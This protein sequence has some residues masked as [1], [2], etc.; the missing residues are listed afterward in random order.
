MMSFLRFLGVNMA[1]DAPE[2]AGQ[3]VRNYLGGL[4]FIVT[5]IGAELMKEGHTY[6]G[7]ALVVAGLPIFL[8]GVLWKWLRT[9]LGNRVSAWLSAI[10]SDSRWWIVSLLVLA[11]IALLLVGP[12]GA[13]LFLVFALSYTVNA[14]LPTQRRDTPATAT[15]PA[16]PRK[17]AQVDRDLLILLD[18]AMYQSAALMIDNLIRSAPA[19]INE[20]FK[21]DASLADT[22]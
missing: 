8:S 15:Q 19:A 11:G 14:L 12:L 20:P 13:T 3:A 21:L 9:K 18:F 2:N 6:G 16:A 22:Y 17:D 4:G 1:D 10:A 5:L 7:A